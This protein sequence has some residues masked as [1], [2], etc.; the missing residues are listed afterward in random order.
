MYR[1]WQV[2]RFLEYSGRW[3]LLYLTIARNLVV[4]LTVLHYGACVFFFIGSYVTFGYEALTPE[5]AS[6]AFFQLSREQVYEMTVAEQCGL[7]G[8][9]SIIDQNVEA[10]HA[11]MKNKEG[12]RLREEGTARGPAAQATTLRSPSTPSRYI[13]S[14]YWSCITFATVGC[15]HGVP[16]MPGEG[17]HAVARTSTL[18]AAFWPSGRMSSIGKRSWGACCR[19]S[20]VPSPRG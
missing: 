17:R 11:I 19:Y 2:A 8:S 6:D 20:G 12:C 7:Q 4:V 13:I 18:M 15:G 14:L 10:F 3:S 9:M 5:N 1:V 16:R